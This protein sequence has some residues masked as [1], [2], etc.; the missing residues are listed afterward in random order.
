M[1]SG[2]RTIAVGLVLYPTNRVQPLMPGLQSLEGR[3]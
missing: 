1:T 2:P 3:S